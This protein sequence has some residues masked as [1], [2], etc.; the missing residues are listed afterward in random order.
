L[1]LLAMALAL[2]AHAAVA[3]QPAAMSEEGAKRVEASK[4]AEYR[5]VLAAYDGALQ[6]SPRDASLAVDRCR[7]I[8]KYTDDEYGDYVDSAPDEF[9]ACQEALETQWKD[10]PPAQMFGLEQLWGEAAIERGEELLKGADRWPPEVRRALL[11][12][13][14]EAQE[15]E[16]PDRAGE[17][18][19]QAVRLG[20][21][22]RVPRA[23]RYLASRRQY[24]E[25]GRLLAG[26]PA[27]TDAW[28]ARQ[29]VEAALELPD[30][31]ASLRELK[32]YHGGEWKIATAAAARAH[33]RA[34][35]VRT[36]R[37]L[38]AADKESGEP[39]RQ[40]RFDAAI[41]AGDTAAAVATVGFS[42]FDN[43]A[44]NLQRFLKLAARTPA[45]L[46]QGAMPLG[47]FVMLGM[48]VLLALVPGLLLLPVHYRG[49]VRRSRGRPATPLFD[50]IGLR[51]AWWAGAVFLAV[52]MTVAMVVDP[53][54]IPSLM[55]GDIPDGAAAFKMMFWGSL[56]GL[57][58]LL[59]ALREVGA[60][61]LLGDRGA[62]RTAAWRVPAAWA[63]I[64]ATGMAIAFWHGHAGGGGDTLQTKTMDAL[65]SGGARS[66]GALATLLLVAALVPCF[67]ELVF[68]GLLLGGMT[69]HIGF[70][71][72]NALQAAVF[73]VA[74]DDPPR[75]LFYL[76]MA[77]LCGW[78]V[79]R[80]KALGPAIALHA[81]NNALAFALM[82]VRG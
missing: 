2:W 47:L 63:C 53:D 60:R 19:V 5:K 31:Q 7:F 81:L 72:A 66:Y 6:A 23:V 51:R 62:W 12:K 75:L 25:A 24:A 68:R 1:R 61:R 27:A 43:F 56:A 55:G 17:L 35:D 38:L 76:T 70:G 15:D 18:A 14:S 74:H 34:G 67:E 40:L 48:G 32:R 69:R 20:E 57:L 71:W 65:A 33:L 73:A 78:L 50:G 22:S 3:A 52:P 13:V 37:K 54:M 64:V 49:L 45:S 9:R 42:D 82:I 8:A 29:R 11:A 77:L 80:T 79:K 39:L 58:C 10:A 16:D 26:A 44:Q 46:L 59:P 28:T 36:A 4:L 30:R 21:A 41:T